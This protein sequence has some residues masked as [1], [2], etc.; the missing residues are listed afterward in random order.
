MEISV[1]YVVVGE[2]HLVLFRKEDVSFFNSF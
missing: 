2:V 1:E